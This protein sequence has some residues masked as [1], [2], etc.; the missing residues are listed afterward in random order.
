MGILMQEPEGSF[1]VRDS[2]SN[3]GC[4]ALSVKNTD[5]KILHYLIVR[6]EKGCYLQVSPSVYW[7]DCV[8][9]DNSSLSL[10]LLSVQGTD[11]HHPN[12]TSLI[13]H[14]ATNVD[15]LPCCLSLGATNLLSDSK[16]AGAAALDP[17]TYSD[18]DSDMDDE[19][20]FRQLAQL[21]I[22]KP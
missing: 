17:E 15:H 11:R 14:H 10:S 21:S 4:L 5:G 7:P 8:Q 20:M 2:A 3:P 6:D 12:L 13:L 16:P 18:E 22:L 1:V 19:E 9:I